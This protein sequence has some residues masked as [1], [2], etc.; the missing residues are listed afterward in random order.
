MWAQRGTP[1]TEGG[2]WCIDSATCKRIV[3]EFVHNTIVDGG[4]SAFPLQGYGVAG[5]S[6]DS[7]QF[8]LSFTTVSPRFH[9]QF[10]LRFHLGFPVIL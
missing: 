10:H 7:I 1:D 5:A 2:S 9:L 8:H 3:V 4:S 6:L